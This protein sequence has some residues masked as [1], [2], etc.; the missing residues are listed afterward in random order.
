MWWGCDPG[1]ERLPSMGTELDPVFSPQHSVVNGR[2]G[3]RKEEKRGGGGGGGG[4]AGKRCWWGKRGRLE[5][6]AVLA[7]DRVFRNL[8]IH[9]SAGRP[10]ASN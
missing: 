10:S 9:G 8:D 7:L 4:D 5:F 2:K 3:A 1:I 6:S